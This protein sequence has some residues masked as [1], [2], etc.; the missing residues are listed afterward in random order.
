MFLPD[1]FDGHGPRH[2]AAHPHFYILVVSE[3][4]SATAAEGFLPNGVFGHLVEMVA[5]MVDDV[6]WFLEKSHR[7][8]RVAGVV[9]RDPLCV[10]PGRIELQ[11]SVSNQISSE[12]DD[13]HH[14][15]GFSIFKTR[16]RD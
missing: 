16:P 1:L 2:P 3:S 4:R 10:V 12:F 8:G 14:L 7:P 11:F 6:A 9:E 13:V 5:D 15:G